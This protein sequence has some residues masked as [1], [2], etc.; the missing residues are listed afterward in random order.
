MITTVNTK[1]QQ[2]ENGYFKIGNG[3]EVILIVGSCRCVQ[4]VNYF[5]Y[6]NRSGNGEDCYTIIFIDPYNW[7]FDL[8]DNRT[9]FE[10]VILSL[11]TDER[12]LSMLPRVDIYLHEYYQHFGLFNTSK[13]AEK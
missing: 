13:D 3:E 9:N 11:E 6:L 1:Q 12:I 2:L 5:N 7:C 10:E 8:N 4:Y